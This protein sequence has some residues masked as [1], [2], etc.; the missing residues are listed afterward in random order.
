MAHGEGGVMMFLTIIG[1]VN[2]VVNAQQGDLFRQTK[3]PL[4]YTAEG[5]RGGGVLKGSSWQPRGKKW[6][7]SSP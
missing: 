1:H 4:Q 2:I 6:C 7:T 5:L 3:A